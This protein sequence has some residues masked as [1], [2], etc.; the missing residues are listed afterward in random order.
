MGTSPMKIIVKLSWVSPYGRPVFKT[1]DRFL[2]VHAH[3]PG[4]GTTIRSGV[5]GL[6]SS[7]L[8]LTDS[9]VAVRLIGP[10]SGFLTGTGLSSMAIGMNIS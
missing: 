1:L 5:E 7:G 3:L 4:R 6:G 8:V 9:A 10:I 2:A